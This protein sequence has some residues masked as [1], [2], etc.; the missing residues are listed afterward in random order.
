MRISDALT[1]IT[2]TVLERRVIQCDEPFLNELMYARRMRPVKRVEQVFDIRLFGV[3]PGIS[4]HPAKV[5]SQPTK[6]SIPENVARS[7]RL[8]RLERVHGLLVDLIIQACPELHGGAILR[9]FK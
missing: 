4:H 1:Q 8:V 7:R 3:E 6:P 5:L 9:Y 2:R